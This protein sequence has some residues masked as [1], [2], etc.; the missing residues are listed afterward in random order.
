MLQTTK[1]PKRKP[2]KCFVAFPLF[3]VLPRCEQAA[4][5]F[6]GHSPETFKVLH[7]RFLSST[8]PSKPLFPCE[9]VSCQVL[10][11]SKGEKKDNVLYNQILR[12]IVWVFWP[13]VF[14]TPGSPR[15]T[16]IPLGLMQV[17]LWVHKT[18]GHVPIL[19]SWFNREVWRWTW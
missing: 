8:S 6:C 19:S 10:G 5:C 14:L 11:Y 17:G 2:S 12:S 7:H 4:P 15:T 16:K 13:F 1:E 3:P 9:F 18:I